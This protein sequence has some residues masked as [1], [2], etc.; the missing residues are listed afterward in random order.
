MGEAST[1][2]GVLDIG[3]YLVAFSFGRD[4]L[5]YTY[6][7]VEFPELKTQCGRTSWKPEIVEHYIWES[8]FILSLTLLEKFNGVKGR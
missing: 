3:I 5:S 1:N 8:Q 7:F 4:R 2:F 6:T